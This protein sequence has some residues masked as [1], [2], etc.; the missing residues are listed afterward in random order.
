[1][2]RQTIEDVLVDEDMK[3]ETDDDVIRLGML[4][5]LSSIILANGKTVRIPLIYV[6]LVEDIQAFNDY[7][8]GIPA[9][10]MTKDT[11]RSAVSNKVKGKGKGSAMQY[12]LIGF[13]H[14]LLV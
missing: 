6:E 5:V 1:M 11:I 4:Y 2:T 7:P 3:F 12:T 9:W 13:P 14:S 8:W 10:E